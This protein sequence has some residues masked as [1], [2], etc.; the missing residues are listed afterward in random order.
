MSTPYAESNDRGY[1]LELEERAKS[2]M[3]AAEDCADFNRFLAFR[4]ASL[5]VEQAA[6]QLR[7]SLIA[8]AVLPIAKAEGR[9]WY[10]AGRRAFES[11]FEGRKHE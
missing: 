6:V 3:R 5:A 11:T 8:A 2:L 9:P 4:Y 1:C 10:N 7:Q